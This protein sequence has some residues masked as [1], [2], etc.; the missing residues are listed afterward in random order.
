MVRHGDI[1]AY[2]GHTYSQKAPGP[3]LRDVSRLPGDEAAGRHTLC[4]CDRSTLVLSL[5]GVVL[6][7]FFLLVLVRKARERLEPGLE[8]QPR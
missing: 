4:G 1:S 6:P 3:C 7:A 8:P 5:F 2:R